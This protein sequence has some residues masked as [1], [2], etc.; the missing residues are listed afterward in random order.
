MYGLYVVYGW[1]VRNSIS[2]SLC[3]Y[4]RIAMSWMLA[5]MRGNRITLRSLNGACDVNIESID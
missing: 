5:S 2:I 3:H 4:R 1:C